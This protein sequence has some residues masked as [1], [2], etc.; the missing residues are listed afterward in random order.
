MGV[1]D[2]PEPGLPTDLT[3]WAWVEILKPAKKF[4]ARARPEMLFLANLQYKICGRPAQARARPELDPKTEARRVQWDDHGQDFLN[5]KKPGFL[6]QPT[7]GMLMSTPLPSTH[8][9][10]SI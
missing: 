6:T 10:H 5:P 2:P 4:L 9:P 3:G 1:G 7:C 8:Q